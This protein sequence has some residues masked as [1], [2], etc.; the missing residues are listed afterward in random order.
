M[1][2]I[3]DRRTSFYQWD[4]NQKLVVDS[5]TI[6][7]VHFCNRT[8]DCSLVCE[9]YDLEGLRVVDVPN[10]LL[11]TASRIY[12]YG[13]C[14]NYTKHEDSFVVVG[15]TK[16][17]DYVYTETEVKSYEA[18]EK[19]LEEIESVGVSQETINKGI[20][21]YLKENPINGG[22]SEEELAQIQANKNDI[23]N[24]SEQI[25]QLKQSGAGGV[26]KAMSD[27]L[28]AIVQ[29]TAYAEVLTEAELLAFKNAWG[30]EHNEEEPDIP[31]TPEVTLTNITVNYTGGDVVTGTNL[32][33]LTGITVKAHYSD[34]T[35]DTVT[36]YTL[37]GEIVEGSNT[38]TVTYKD[39]KATFI[40]L[41]I[42]ESGDGRTLLHNWVL[43]ADI[44][45]TET[46]IVSGAKL[47]NYYAIGYD[48]GWQI[49]NNWSAI[50]VLDVVT[51]NRTIELDIVTNADAGLGDKSS[52]LFNFTT[53][54][55]FGSLVVQCN[56]GTWEWI[57]D[58]KTTTIIEGITGINAFSGKTVAFCIDSNGTVSMYLNGEYIS[59]APTTIE[60]N[61]FFIG[62]NSSGYFNVEV[63]GIRI[64]E[65][66]YDESL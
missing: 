56:K 30:I 49:E 34:N 38:I 2:K 62:R 3:Y 16:P 24:L 58:G 60:T 8:D 42:A 13:Y 11:Q 22:A 7:Q 43:G 61:S 4:L 36:D 64:Y 25:N 18:L 55:W 17:T 23:N 37:S 63:S 47:S 54:D 9:V 53:G 48:D 51:A 45:N 46:D 39:K 66:V 15:R 21:E 28:W 33:D 5:N 26:T 19:R 6:N 57:V 52:T 35:S 40:V 12:V 1:F 14:E 59:T 29:K 41:G 50:K 32:T 10:V 31:D 27:S 44:G 65:G 20:E